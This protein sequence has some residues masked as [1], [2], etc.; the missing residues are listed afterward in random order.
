MRPASIFLII[1]LSNSRENEEKPDWGNSSRER[2][3][4]FLHIFI[5]F[6]SG[7]NKVPAGAARFG[8]KETKVLT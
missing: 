6:Y 8:K 3:K 4:E 7:M 1:Q 2:K 5:P